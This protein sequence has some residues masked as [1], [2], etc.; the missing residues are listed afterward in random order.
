[1]YA[2]EHS[3]PSRCASLTHLKHLLPTPYNLLPTQPTP[4]ASHRPVPVV[5]RPSPD[6]VT[7]PPAPPSSQALK[8][9]VLDVT[10]LSVLLLERALRSPNIIGY[11]FAWG[12]LVRVPVAYLLGEQN[13]I[14]DT[15]CLHP[16]KAQL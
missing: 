10:P 16:P 1:M 11:P 9:E 14:W 15:P 7:Y 13:G 4:L 5:N 12:C 6:M 3:S 2:R 8:F